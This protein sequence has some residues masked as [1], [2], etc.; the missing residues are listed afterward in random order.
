MIEKYLQDIHYEN[1]NPLYTICECVG[2]NLYQCH[3]KNPIRPEKKST[4]TTS[5]EQWKTVSYTHKR[6]STTTPTSQK[7]EKEYSK[8][9]KNETEKKIRIGKK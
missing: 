9:E 2:H 6:Y 4:A 8:N 1:T 3:N 5:N 7:T